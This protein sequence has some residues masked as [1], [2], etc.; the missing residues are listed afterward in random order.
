MSKSKDYQVIPSDVT[1]EKIIELCPG[2]E[3]PRGKTHAVYFD[4]RSAGKTSL[5]EGCESCCLRIARRIRKGL[6]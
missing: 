1:V 5:F 4:S 2:C 3:M 6:K